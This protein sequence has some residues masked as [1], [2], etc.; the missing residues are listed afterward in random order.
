MALR[1]MVSDLLFKIS[2]ILLYL[3][4][5]PGLLVKMPLAFDLRVLQMI[6]PSPELAR[7]ALGCVFQI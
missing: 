6:G 5:L 1:Q 7:A 2:C 3:K 4:I